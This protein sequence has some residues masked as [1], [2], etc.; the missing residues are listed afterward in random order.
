MLL[1]IFLALFLGILCGIITGC[2]QTRL[3]SKSNSWGLS[4]EYRTRNKRETKNSHIK[5]YLVTIHIFRNPEGRLRI[6][7]R[8]ESNDLRKVA[9]TSIHLV[10]SSLAL[11]KSFAKYHQQILNTKSLFYRY[12]KTDQSNSNLTGRGG[13]KIYTG[14]IRGAKKSFQ[15]TN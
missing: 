13:T 1:E 11:K 3:L 4:Y 5:T 7:E 9:K 6:W 15:S 10:A 8:R 2:N 12:G 14:S